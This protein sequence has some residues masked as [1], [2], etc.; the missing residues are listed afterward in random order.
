VT[1]QPGTAEPGTAE[2]LAEALLVSTQSLMAM[3]IRTAG[4]APVPVTVVQYRVLLLLE[5]A[6]N[7]SVNDVAAALGVDQSTAS[8]HCTRLARLGLLRR[9]QASHDRRA[10]ELRLTGSGRAEVQA[11]REA[12]RRWAEQV[13]TRLTDDEARSAVRGLAVFAAAARALEA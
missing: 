9:T 11:V 7:L 6:G 5:E 10:A 3:A 12:R 8:R 2:E 1:T 4:A 13:L